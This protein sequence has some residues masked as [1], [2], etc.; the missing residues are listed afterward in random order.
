M[1]AA[2]HRGRCYR[3][4]RAC[5][6]RPA[7]AD[8][9]RAGRHQDVHRRAGRRPVDRRSVDRATRAWARVRRDVASIPASVRGSPGAGSTP[10]ARRHDRRRPAYRARRAWADRSR[11][12]RRRDVRHRAGRRRGGHRSADHA[13]PAWGRVHR[14]AAS[15]PVWVLV[16]P[17]VTSIPAWVRGNPAAGSTPAARRSGRH[18]CRR[19]ACRARPVSA[20]RHSTRAWARGA[21]RP[22]V[23]AGR[24]SPWPAE[25]RCPWST[26]CRQTRPRRP[27]QAPSRRPG[28]ARSRPRTRHRRTT[29][30]LPPGLRTR[31]RS[32][33]RPPARR[34]LHRA[35][36][37]AQAW[38]APSA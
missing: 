37:R 15:I 13:T 25:P 35:S 26:V 38:T 8:R 12:G 1:L 20:G 17:A 33:R 16:N 3:P 4:H 5:R 11:A 24:A 23:S 19:R 10:G 28:T 9:S 7:W 2:R 6:A 36:G 34:R 32:A 29:H 27:I 18:H 22:R 31:L 14:D 21:H 30:C